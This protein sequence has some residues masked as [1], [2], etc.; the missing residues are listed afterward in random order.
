[1]I[2]TERD[3]GQ[4]SFG[5]ETAAAKKKVSLATRLSSIF[6]N[7]LSSKGRFIGLVF[8][9]MIILAFVMTGI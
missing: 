3:F 8:V 5:G 9:A 1:M 2:D 6:D 4:G 7:A